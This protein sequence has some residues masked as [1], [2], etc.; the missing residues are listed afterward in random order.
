MKNADYTI[1]VDALAVGLTRP[2]L[3]MGINLRLF[4]FNLAFCVLLCV[5]AK[6]LLGVPLFVVNYIVMYRLSSKEPNFFFIW[7]IAFTK[8]P[9]TLNSHFWGRTNSYEPW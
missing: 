1:E 9:P 4:F 8:T 5:D 7:F 2:P 3:F 6:T